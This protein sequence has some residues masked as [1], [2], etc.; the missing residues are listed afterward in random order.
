MPSERYSCGTPIR[1]PFTPRAAGGLEIRHRHVGAGRILRV[2]PRHR[3]QQDRRVPHGPRERPRVI[4]RRRERHHAP[5][6]AP[7]IGRLHPHQPAKRRRLPDRAAGI[8]P[9]RPHRQPRRHR[10]RR[11]ARRSARHQ[12]RGRH[13]AAASTGS[14]PARNAEVM[15]DDP[16]ANS[17]MLVLPRN[18]A[19]SRS[20]LAVTVLSYGGTNGSRILLPAVVRTPAVQNRSLIASGMPVS[21]RA[22]PCRQRRIRRS[23][24][25][26]RLGVTDG[27]DTRSA[28]GSA[29]RSH[30]DAPSSGRRRR[31]PSPRSAVAGLGDRQVGEH[32]STTFGTAKK[33]PIRSGALDS[34]C[35]RIAAVGDDVLAHRQRHVARRR[36]A[37][38]RRRHRPHSTARS[39][40]GCRSV[41]WHSVVHL[42]LLHADAGERGDA[43]DGR[44]IERHRDRIPWLGEGAGP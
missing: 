35:V 34:T 12:H 13:P 33:S 32:H 9:R 11:P 24:L 2:V 10:R 21:G 44:V 16:M 31:I 18:T 42:V 43:A 22:S 6:R 39:S 8:G 3:A 17:S 37:D 30:A 20:R 29:P 36:S 26:H 40:P 23:R 28:A 14:P 5:A 7:P 15:F 4:Q 41:R 1:R 25:L 19:P 27:D 38:R